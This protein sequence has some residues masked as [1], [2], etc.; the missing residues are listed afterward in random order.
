MECLVFGRRAGED[1]AAQAP[2]PPV[3]PSTP[4][5]FTRHGLRDADAV[6]SAVRAL[7]GRYLG[8]LRAGEGL[9][10]AREELMGLLGALEEIV[11]ETPGEAWKTAE[12]TAAGLV[13]LLICEFARGRRES[14][15]SHFREDFPV[16]S[17]HFQLSQRA[18]IEGDKLLIFY[19]D[20]QRE[21]ELPPL[22][23]DNVG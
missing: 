1:A 11:A 17:P 9:A 12:A 15:G 14:R 13:A 18:R 2:V 4:D 5:P 16:P 10:R 8:P 21:V 19:G 22:L 7:A 20:F 3:P 23:L 6:I